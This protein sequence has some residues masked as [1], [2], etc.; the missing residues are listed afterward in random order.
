VSSVGM[1]FSLAMARADESTRTRHLE[2][3]PRVAAVS[4]AQPNGCW[5]W[6]GSRDESGYGHT[7][8]ARRPISTHRLSWETAFGPIPRG[9]VICH[10]CDNPPCFNPAHLFLGTYADNARDCLQKGRHR[11]RRKAA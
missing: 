7:T 5:E 9:L 4:G 1:D 8:I 3:I 6:E 10:R 2:A 11:T